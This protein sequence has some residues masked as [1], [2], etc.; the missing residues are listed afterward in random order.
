M[1]VRAALLERARARGGRVVLPEGGD[2]RVLAL[3]QHDPLAARG[4]ALEE[5]LAEAH[6]A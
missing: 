1:S 3:A 5:R 2:P 6:W 4:R